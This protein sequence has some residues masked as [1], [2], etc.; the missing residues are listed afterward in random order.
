MGYIDFL[1]IYYMMFV[2]V[3]YLMNWTQA[4][5]L[6]VIMTLKVRCDIHLRKKLFKLS[7]DVR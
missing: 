4:F 7:N 3:I 5:V 2:N 6:S 1:N